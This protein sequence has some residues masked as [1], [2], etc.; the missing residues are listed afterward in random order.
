MNATAPES[1]NP[2]P[3][4]PPPGSIPFAADEQESVTRVGHSL[5]ATPPLRPRR[6]P[7]WPIVTLSAALGCISSTLAFDTL[8]SQPQAI[9]QSSRPSS[10]DPTDSV[11]QVATSQRW[12]APEVRVVIDESVHAITPEAEQAIV[13]AFGAWLSASPNLPELNIE[14]GRGMKPR[15]D[16]DGVNAVVYAP[17]EFPGHEDDLAITIG[18]SD[19][20]TGEIT[21]AD[22]I[23]NSRHAY[24]HLN[25]PTPGAPSASCDGTSQASVCDYRYDLQNVMTHEVGHFY[26][27]GEDREDRTATMYSC[28]SACETHKRDVSEGDRQTMGRL[29]K[30]AIQMQSRAVSCDAARLAPR[31]PTWGWAGA[32]ALGLIA[33]ARRRRA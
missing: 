19:E 31:G 21:E 9:E 26:G 7:R 17:I 22:I 28:T 5:P 11:A 13:Q 6:T 14:H 4:R 12:M 8:D 25:A 2:T 30:D 18:F 10:A 3:S 32:L 1:P 33:F 29:Y 15:L 23:I 20:E 27:L 16:P 24:S